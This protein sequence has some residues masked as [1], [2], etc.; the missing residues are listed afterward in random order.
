MS[1]KTEKTEIGTDIVIS[2]WEEGVTDNP[3]SGISN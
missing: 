1:F 2:G 3:Y